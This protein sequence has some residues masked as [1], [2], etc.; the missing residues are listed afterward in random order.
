MISP[1]KFFRKYS[2]VLVL[3]LMSLLLVIFLLDP[4]LT[5]RA[6]AEG[7]GRELLGTAFGRKI[8]QADLNRAKAD[9][10]LLAELNFPVQVFGRGGMEEYL[11]ALLLMEE[12]DRLGIRF[13]QQQVIEELRRRNV[14][15]DWI[16]RI[17]E[18]RRRSLAS[19][20]ESVGRF[21]ACMTAA[22]LHAS[23]ARESE[24]RLEDAYRL[25]HQKARVRL[26]VIESRALRA[27]VPAPSEEELAAFFEAGKNR[28]TAHTDDALVFGYRRPDRIRIEYLTIDPAQ[29]EARVRISERE[30]RRHYELHR[31][32]YAA[33]LRTET[34][35]AGPPEFDQLPRDLR[36]RI[37]NE[38]RRA[39][40]IAEAQQRVN[41]ML[42]EARAPWAGQPLEEDGYRAPPPPGT[43][44]E[45]SALRDRHAREY[46]VEHRLSELIAA[47]DVTLDPQI[48]QA[49]VRVGEMSLPL[50][51]VV[52]RVKGLYTPQPQET[53][54]PVNI[55][56]PCPDLAVIFKPDPLSRTPLP[57]QA[58]L[59]R[60]TEV[61][62]AGPPASLEEV[63]EQ[64]LKD[65]LLSRAHELAGEAAHRLAERA[66][67]VG[68]DQAVDEAA[69]LRQ[70]LEAA[71]QAQTPAPGEPEIPFLDHLGPF[72][73]PAQFGRRAS[74]IPRVGNVPKLHEEIFRLADE[75]PAATRPA[76]AVVVV[77]SPPGQKWIV[78]ELL[79]VLPLYAGDFAE[80]RSALSQQLDNFHQQLAWR[81]WFDPE[82]VRRRTGFQ[83][84]ARR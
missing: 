67:E 4:V 21:L 74:F 32:Q 29:I 7:Y 25:F 83:E 45:F 24:P 17:R 57:Y 81:L 62:P 73:A 80:Q 82:N 2:R 71:Q 41:V 84:A 20:Y 48:G 9:V 40:A 51:Q 23:A 69:E 28:E 43:R 63:R 52:T 13:S 35:P 14:P 37:R 78:G 27:R 15:D 22:T 8:T 11:T 38:A 19:I 10:E 76:R 53:F 49:R 18:G 30:A 60:I 5:R 58:F 68:L 79:E 46:P 12:A 61:A 47:A 59:F 75:S 16:D 6:D 44:V 64:V 3:V 66:R 50:S 77:P 55:N 42:D 31:A 54:V 34:A 70:L 33:L 56:E 1:I 36:E 39:R 72:D 65:Y 26:A